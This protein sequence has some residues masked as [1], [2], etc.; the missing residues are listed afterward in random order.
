[1]SSRKP[2]LTSPVFTSLIESV[3]AGDIENVS[4]VLTPLSE[5]QRAELYPPL[6]SWIRSFPFEQ[7]MLSQRKSLLSFITACECAVLMTASREELQKWVRAGHLRLGLNE[8]FVQTGF[9][10]Q[11]LTT[12]LPLRKAV[13]T[14]DFIQWL[15]T[16]ET[17]ASFPEYCF[18]WPVW[19]SFVHEGLL[20][21]KYCPKQIN[22]TVVYSLC[23]YLCAGSQKFEKGWFFEKRPTIIDELWFIFEHEFTERVFPFRAHDSMSSRRFDDA[24]IKVLVKDK[25]GRDRLLADLFRIIK[26]YQY[27]DYDKHWYCGIYS[28]L[29]PSVTELNEHQ[30]DWY[31]MLSDPSAS[32]RLLA[33]D[34]LMTLEKNGL[35]EDDLFFSGVIKESNARRRTEADGSESMMYQSS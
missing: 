23:N 33:F 12:A 26:Q 22:E 16:R 18:F 34:S 3:T 28:R 15:M 25:V 11:S 8:S 13:W 10:Q 27:T 14:G 9:L 19:Y 20:N 17:Y 5:E 30:D 4:S 32:D 24:L 7:K 2:S 35:L 6:I 21:E 29:S 1:M 31:I